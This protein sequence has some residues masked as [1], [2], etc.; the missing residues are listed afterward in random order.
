MAVSPF[1]ALSSRP[2]SAG[3][4]SLSVNLP[5]DSEERLEFTLV[6]PHGVD[7]AVEP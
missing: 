6:V 1:V 5:E 4:D 2:T 3:E 7:V